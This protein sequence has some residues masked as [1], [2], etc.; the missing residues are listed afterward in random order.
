MWDFFVI[1]VRLPMTIVWALLLTLIL[2]LG[3]IFTIVAF[4]LMLIGL[5]F[6]LINALFNNTPSDLKHYANDMIAWSPIEAFRIYFDM[7]E[8]LFKWTF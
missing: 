2:P 1:I 8:N 7:I 6:K 5:P 4:L 3:I